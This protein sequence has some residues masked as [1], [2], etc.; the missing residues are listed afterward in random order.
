MNGIENIE[1]RILDEANAKA[2]AIIKDAEEKAAAITS[3][4]EEKIKKEIT[5]INEKNVL[6]LQD[7][8][9]KARQADKME[10][11]KK[12][13]GKKYEIVSEVF[14]KAQEAIMSMDDEKYLDLLVMLASNSMKDNLGGELLFNKADREKFGQRVV[15]RINSAVLSQK[16]DTAKKAVAAVVD[17]LKE[18]QMPDAGKVAEDVKTGFSKKL[19]TLSDETAN[20]TGGVVVRRDKIEFNCD[21][22]VIIRILSDEM[23]SEV[24]DRLFPKGA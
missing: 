1:K 8:M 5:L 24:Y 7:I 6:L 18:G 14:K 17:S 16:A 2:D 19:V 12:I 3:E 20:I 10:R 11:R 15:D 21:I 22:A 4:Y 13:S 23:A 9:L